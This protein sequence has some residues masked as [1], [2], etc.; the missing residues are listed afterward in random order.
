MHAFPRK[1][2]VCG[3]ASRANSHVITALNIRGPFDLERA[4]NRT[5]EGIDALA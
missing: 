2:I 1:F 4:S 3:R 5:S